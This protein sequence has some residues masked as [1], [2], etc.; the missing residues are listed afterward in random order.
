MTL[1]TQTYTAAEA[2]AINLVDELSDQPEE[3]LRRLA[4]R[5]ARLNE[6]TIYNLK[7]YFRKM[8]I[9]NEETEKTAIQ[10]LSRLISEPQVQNNIKNFVESGKFPWEK[11]S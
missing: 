6:K 10:E 11:K 7:H 1:T 2:H 3:V 5:F 4:I 8:W 9:I